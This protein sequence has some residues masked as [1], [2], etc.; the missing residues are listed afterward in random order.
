MECPECGSEAYGEYHP[1]KTP[2]G[3]TYGVKICWECPYVERMFEQ[4]KRD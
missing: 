3:K 1:L 2:S 4:P